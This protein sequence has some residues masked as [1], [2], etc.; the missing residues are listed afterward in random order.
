MLFTGKGWCDY[1]LYNPNF[2]KNNLIQRVF[3][4]EKK[5]QKIIDGLKIAETSYKEKQKLLTNILN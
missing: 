2:K 4:D 1:L 3:A 5:Q